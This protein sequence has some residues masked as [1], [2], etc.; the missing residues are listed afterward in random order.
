MRRS[1]SRDLRNLSV[2]DGGVDS[3]NKY[4]EDSSFPFIR[5]SKTIIPKTIIPKTIIPK[6][7]I[8]KTIIP[9]TIIPKT[10]II[11]FSQAP[12]TTWRL[13]NFDLT[14]PFS[15]TPTLTSSRKQGP[16]LYGKRSY[17]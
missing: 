3:V 2:Y 17:H 9:K 11:T 1:R 8:P 10:I 15:E 7:I 13:P 12:I 4:F 14:L 16:D 5:I 6:T